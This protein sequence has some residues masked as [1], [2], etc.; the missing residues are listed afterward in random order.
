MV[1]SPAHLL[2]DRVVFPRIQLGD[3][4]MKR[5]LKGKC[6]GERRRGVALFVLGNLNRTLT[7]DEIRYVGLAEARSFSV[8]AQIVVEF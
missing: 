5:H 1:C 3:W 8:S 2:A 6:R 4:N 7:A